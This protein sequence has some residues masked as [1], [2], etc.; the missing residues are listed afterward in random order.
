MPRSITASALAAGAL[1]ALLAGASAPAAGADDAALR[2]AAADTFR[3]A[4]D[5]RK[6]EAGDRAT[7][8]PANPVLFVG[9]SS[10]RMWTSLAE[11]FP[12][13][14]VLNRGFGGSETGDLIR[15]LDRVVYPYRP[16][17]VVL[18]EGDNDLA[19]G[20]SPERVAADLDTVVA[21]IHRNLPGTP[22]A[23]LSVK[24]SLARRALLPAMHR[25]N[26]T[27]EA[28]ARSDS[29][30]DYVDVWTPMLQDNGLPRPELFLPDGLHMDPV[31]YVI[32]KRALEPY[33]PKPRE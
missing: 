29:L 12:G 28:R 2:P 30:L 25:V 16:R 19:A 24:P 15:Y 11:D 27:M 22:V 3:F 21:R 5:I 7:P 8:P 18:Y 4:A 9:S 32:W 31:G 6:F 10:I 1:A 14:P 23:F 17:M 26:E 20:K 33:L 13:L